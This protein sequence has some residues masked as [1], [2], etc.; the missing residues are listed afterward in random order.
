MKTSPCIHPGWLWLSERAS[1][2]QPPK[3]LLQ[4]SVTYFKSVRKEIPFTDTFL[5]T[6]KNTFDRQQ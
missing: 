6:E 1:Y 3:S 4:P 5:S 2:F